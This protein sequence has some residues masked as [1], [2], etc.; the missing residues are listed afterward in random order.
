MPICLYAYMPIFTYCMVSRFAAV[1]L[2]SCMLEIVFGQTMLSCV[3]TCCSP[4]SMC[5]VCGLR[6]RQIFKRTANV[7][8]VSTAKTTIIYLHTL[9]FKIYRRNPSRVFC[10]KTIRNE[11]W[12]QFSECG[13]L[14]MEL[15][16][17][18]SPYNHP[19]S[20]EPAFL[21]M[22]IPLI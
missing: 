21:F 10:M 5:D 18:L 12:T 9:I 14:G 13:S 20:D 11:L 19:C 1:I 8:S 15:H 22:C 6:S 3:G 7:S 17:Q 4:L 16:I 2:C